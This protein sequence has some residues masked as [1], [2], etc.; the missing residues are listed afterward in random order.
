[1]KKHRQF[2]IL[3]ALF[4]AAL[5]FLPAL[6]V[7]AGGSAVKAKLEE[8]EEQNA[9]LETENA[10]YR[11]QLDSKNAAIQKL[12][13]E[14][15]QCEAEKRELEQK[16]AEYE[17]LIAYWQG[18]IEAYG[19][20]P[21]DPS[22]ISMT[23]T[24]TLEQKNAQIV[25]LERDV[26]TLERELEEVEMQLEIATR[27]LEQAE[28]EAEQLRMQTTLAERRVRD[29][30]DENEELLQALEVYE[31]IQEE[32]M[33]LMDIALDRIQYVLRDEIRRGEVRVFKGT[34]G[35]TIDVV[36]AH[37]FDT[38][39][40]ELTRQGRAILSKIA[41]LLEELDGYSIGV[42]GNADRRPIIT[43]ALREKS[44]TNWELSAARGSSVVRFFLDNADIDPRRMVA[45]GLGQ[46]Q[47]IDRRRN[48]EGY[49]NNRRVDIVLLPIDAIAAV[50]IGAEVK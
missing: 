3:V 33:V 34:L 47:P 15:R 7:Y 41:G 5:I 50:V 13:R 46:Y 22:V 9:E 28:R 2:L 26:E 39:G 32:S 27:K 10:D 18:E 45:M 6:S 38:G 48:E 36:S 42:I 21:E 35:I 40:V 31:A 12:D 19:F 16:I 37:M 44:P 20:D 30:E 11:T 1:M 8:C 49:G 29:L 14:K 17:E 23:I 24:E 4:I 43:P 25:E